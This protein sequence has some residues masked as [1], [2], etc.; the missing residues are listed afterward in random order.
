MR[1]GVFTDSGGTSWVYKAT[2]G[3]GGVQLE[4]ST[5]SGTSNPLSVTWANYGPVFGESSLSGPS[6]VRRVEAVCPTDAG[7]ICAVGTHNFDLG[8]STVE[9]FWVVSN[10]QVIQL[11]TV[12][13]LPLTEDFVS[14]NGNAKYCAYICA[15]VGTNGRLNVFANDQV[16]GRAVTFSIQNGIESEVRPV[17]PI[18][19]SASGVS[20]TPISC[21]SINGLYRLV[22]RFVRSV[23]VGSSTI[24][25][26]AFDCYLT[27]FDCETWSFG[28]RS[29]YI[30]GSS[31]SGTLIEY[32]NT[33]YCIGNGRSF[34]AP[35]NTTNAYTLTPY[36]ISWSFES[37]TN[38]ADKLDLVLANPTVSGGSGVL[39]G[40]SQLKRGSTIYFSAGYSGNLVQLGVYS[41]DEVSET[42][43]ANGRSDLKITCRDTGQKR[44]ID[45]NIALTA[46]YESRIS[47]DTLLTSLNDLTLMSPEDSG[48]VNTSVGLKYTGLNEPFFAYAECAENGNVLMKATVSTSVTD[49]YHLS[50]IGFVFGADESG[51]GNVALVPKANGWTGHTQPKPRVRRLSLNPI[52]PSQPDL[53]N[54]GFNFTSRVN[55]LWE[56]NDSSRIR[57]DTA[58]GTY[59]TEPSFSMA[60]ATTYDIAARVSGR[61]VQIFSKPRVTSPTTWAANA[62]YTLQSEFM[63]GNT[64]KRTQAGKDNCGLAL[65]TDVF[66]D[67]DTFA[68]AVHEDIDQQLTDADEISAFTSNVGSGQAPNTAGP[69]YDNIVNAATPAAAIVVGQWIYLTAVHSSVAKSAYVKVS[70]ISGST[71]TF[72]G[73]QIESD[74]NGPVTVYEQ[75]TGDEWAYASSG[76]VSEVATGGARVTTN[77]GAKKLTLLM[78]GRAAFTNEDGSAITIRQV[79]TDGV[80]TY[81]VSGNFNSQGGTGWDETNPIPAGRWHAGGSDP[82]VWRMLLHHGFLFASGTSAYGLPT[83]GTLICDDEKFSYQET[84]YYKRGNDV[85]VTITQIPHYY[86]GTKA[87][88]AGSSTINVWWNGAQELGDDFALFAPGMLVEFIARNG[89]VPAGKQ[90]YISAVNDVGSPSSSSTSSIVLDAPYENELRNYV[91]GPPAINGDFAC[92]SGR[93]RFGSEKV[94]HD[95]DA[96]VAYYPHDSLGNPASITV[97]RFEVYSGAWQSIEDVL[98]KLACMAG[99]RNVTFRNAHTSPSSDVSTTLSTTAYTMP[100][101]SALANFTLDAFVFIPGNDT[102]SGGAINAARLEIGFRSTYTLCVQQK[103][104]AADYAVG[105][106]GNVL[107]SLIT[108]NVSL[109]PNSDGDRL[110]ESV[111]VPI[112]DYNLSGTVSGTNPNYTLNIDV[113]RRVMV[114]LAVHNNLVAVELNG[115]PVW[116]FNLDTYT[117]DTGTSYRSDAAGDITLRYS[118]NQSG[119]T[120]TIRVQELG[121]EEE[122]FTVDLGSTAA[123]TINQILS[124]RRI[125]VRSNSNGGL[126]FSRF[127]VRDELDQLT[128]SMFSEEW[129]VSDTA[130]A[131]HQL[132]TGQIPGE[133]IDEAR[134]ANEGYRFTAASNDAFTTT[135]AANREA[136][137]LI[138]EAAEFASPRSIESVGLVEAQPEDEISIGYTPA[139]DLP[140]HPLQS[141]VITTITLSGNASEMTSEMTLRD[142]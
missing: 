120:A 73:Y 23:E 62:N 136:R 10:T 4:R 95:S 76:S 32:A 12:L 128:N 50:S 75:A 119:N 82:K 116:T 86:F 15:A 54:K 103:A 47:L 83:T 3:I 33:I 111:A 36:I 22:C 78:Q 13:N 129:S 126:T 25:T 27:S 123:N 18:T 127:E 31:V 24:N 5:I 57:T 133:Y 58:S 60:A 43:N 88:S 134:I 37:T 14:V 118:A 105:R 68:Q 113:A 77:P 67:T 114:R 56:N 100:L 101:Q 53:P 16:R 29:F 39:N 97:S 99:V 64:A 49:N 2:H 71:I 84:T 41:I 59:R 9:F 104:S 96:P 6:V 7:I 85:P 30:T 70:S 38:A 109:S 117:T 106:G 1:A 55:A 121:D 107:L 8:F 130:E 65:S 93:G 11:N 92:V 137:L 26:S 40:V 17:V 51:G 79:K 139:G 80:K 72:T 102:N 138:E 19:A 135:E 48:F 132:V 91:A 87:I 112:T 21:T 61:R 89:K 46:D 20:L 42:I 66:V 108:N 74:Q 98:K 110:L 52:D 140:Q 63:F 34:S 45:T 115:Q 35:D 124:A 90:Y 125:R 81:L 28:E 141:H 44:I 142:A 131:S 94:T 69:Y 122:R